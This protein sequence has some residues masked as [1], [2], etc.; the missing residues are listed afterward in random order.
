MIKQMKIFQLK[1]KLID[2]IVNKYGLIVKKIL[3]IEKL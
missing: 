2:L 1:K 3:I